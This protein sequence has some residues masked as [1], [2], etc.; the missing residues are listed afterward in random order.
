VTSTLSM[1]TLTWQPWEDLINQ[2][3]MGFAVMEYVLNLFMI[4]IVIII[5]T[6]SKK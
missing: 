1:L 3:F 5:Q 2:L 4:N 6:I